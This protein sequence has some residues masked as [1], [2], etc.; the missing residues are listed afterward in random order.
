LKGIYEKER[1]VESLYDYFGARY[2]D[3]RIGRRLE[4][5]P[6][7]EKY[8]GWSPFVYSAGN[9]ERFVDVDG[10]VIFEALDVR[11]SRWYQLAKCLMLSTAVGREVWQNSTS[12]KT[13]LSL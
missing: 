11:L 7:A 12:G 2:Y 10:R 13:L 8:P 5:D 6:L 9:P 3:A 1:D 4:V